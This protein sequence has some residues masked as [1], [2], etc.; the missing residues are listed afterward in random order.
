[1]AGT[2][3]RRSGPHPDQSGAPAVFSCS[4]ATSR[5]YRRTEYRF[6]I[7]LSRHYGRRNRLPNR[8]GRVEP[9]PHVNRSIRRNQERDSAVTGR[10][11]RRWRSARPG[12]LAGEP[13]VPHASPARPASRQQE[14]VPKY[15]SAHPKFD[16]ILYICGRVKPDKSLSKTPKTGSK[17]VLE[18][19]KNRKKS[20]DLILP[21]L[22][23]AIQNLTGVA[24]E[25]SRPAETTGKR[26]KP[27]GAKN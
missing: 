11:T 24:P 13:P 9:C 20:H 1:M 15:D 27:A 21:I 2:P 7:R 22:T 5:D 14:R 4:R 18:L 6:P 17:R 16:H 26:A 10:A 12:S 19:N 8:C 3:Y 25:G 23:L